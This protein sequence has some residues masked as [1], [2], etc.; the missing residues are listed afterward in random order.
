MV[1]RTHA[2]LLVAE[3][4]AIA[5]RCALPEPTLT[6][7]HEAVKLYAGKQNM[8]RHNHKISGWII[9]TVSLLL[10][11]V[12][13]GADEAKWMGVPTP[14]DRQAARQQTKASFYDL[15]LGSLPLLG[16]AKADYPDIQGASLH[17][18]VEDIVGFAEESR[19]D[20]NILW[21]RVSGTK[22]QHETAE[23]MQKKFG[24]FGLQKIHTDSL[25][26]NAQWWPTKSR[27]SV[28]LSGVNGKAEYVL[29]SAFPAP[30]SSSITGGGLEAEVVD[31]GLGRPVD[32]LG[33]NVRGKIVVLRSSP[34]LGTIYLMYS[35]ETVP[36]TLAKMG[37]V[38]VITI[39][40]APGNAQTFLYDAFGA[41]TVPAFVLGGD[42]GDF[43]EELI[44]RAEP[45]K[46]RVHMDLQ[47]EYKP[48][49]STENVIGVVPG[50]T[51]EY[52]VIMAHQDGWF[53]GAIDNASGLATML[54]LAQHYAAETRHRKLRRNILFLATAGHHMALGKQHVSNIVDG[55]PSPVA[56]AGTAKFIELYPDILKKT[57]L[58]LNC[59][60][61]ASIATQTGGDTNMM[62]TGGFFQQTLNTENARTL[63]ITNRSPMLLEFFRGAINRYGLVMAGT[64][65]HSPYGDAA[66]LQTIVPVV[67]LIETVGWY[68]ST[69][70]TPD[71]ISP[72]GLERTARAFAYFLDKVDETSRADLERGAQPSRAVSSNK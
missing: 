33:K 9:G 62:A 20:G 39:I 52:V 21:G 16:P 54:N 19:R 63:A 46:L 51:D 31:V 24:E 12:A 58:A 25:M 38:A 2:Q 28:V 37:A 17:K 4:V 60:H 36:A 7:D 40:E 18:Y 5:G 22:Y 61:T 34:L 41:E 43:L 11:G 68:H 65:R 69:A 45:S 30:P 49:S 53:D 47:T 15:D 57:V 67:N 8:S 70:D 35:G 56:S 29:R 59:E 42:D 26:R 14:E 72:Q 71:L 1:A 32:L 55:Y 23:Y 3:K 6:L 13:A 10:V 44:G 27:V 66:M 64:T 50:A 48:P